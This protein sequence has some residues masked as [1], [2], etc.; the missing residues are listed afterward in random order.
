MKKGND[1]L[2]PEFAR[3]LKEGHLVEFSPRGVSM[4]PFIEGAIR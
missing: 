2:I 4:R 1:I 3:L